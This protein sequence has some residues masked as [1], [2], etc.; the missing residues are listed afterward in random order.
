MLV[1]SGT[2]LHTE[3]SLTSAPFKY[4]PDD[5]DLAVYDVMLDPFT[6]SPDDADKALYSVKATARQNYEIPLARTSKQA[7]RPLV[8]GRKE[9]DG[10]GEVEQAAS[11][12]DIALPFDTILH[13]RNPSSESPLDDLISETSFAN[14]AVFVPID[15]HPAKWLTPQENEASPFL[16]GVMRRHLLEQGILRTGRITVSDLRRWVKE[17]RRVIGMNGLR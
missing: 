10:L 8:S 9:A 14:I 16:P 15:G 12:A 4:S 13:W 11:R 1:P 3:M 17:N 6:I 2:R 7:P 5:Q